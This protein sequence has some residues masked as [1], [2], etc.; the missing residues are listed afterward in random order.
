[1]K[2]TTSK[3]YIANLNNATKNI[4]EE[5]IDEILKD[6]VGILEKNDCLDLGEVIVDGYKNYYKSQNDISKIKI[7]SR[8]KISSQT[9]EMIVKK[10]E[11]QIEIEEE[12]DEKMI[13][14]MI[15]EIDS[16]ILI[17]GSIDTKLKNIADSIHIDR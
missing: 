4:P 6:F 7:K 3:E 14:G 16:H 8:K 12:I 1:M 15:I 13:G 9:M 2:K 5:K 10:F 11:N 17:D